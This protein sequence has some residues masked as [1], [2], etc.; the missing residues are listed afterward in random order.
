VAGFDDVS[1][2]SYLRPKLTTIA[3][4]TYEIG[5]S[6]AELLL[7]RLGTAEPDEGDEDGGQ[8]DDHAV[9]LPTHLVTRDSCAPPPGRREPA[10]DA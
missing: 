10:H 2:S 7:D 9:M 8:A 6:A 1:L 5:T 4:T 3:I